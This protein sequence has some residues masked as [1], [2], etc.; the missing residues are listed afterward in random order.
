MLSGG[1]PGSGNAGYVAIER[2]TGKLGAKSGS[3]AVMQQGTMI[4]GSAPQ[5]T[6]T[7]VPGSGTGDLS[8][9]YG[10]MNIMVPGGKHEYEIFYAFAQ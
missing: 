4:K 1:D 10:S 2:I 3:F 6:V 7:I 9:I 8:G 5:M